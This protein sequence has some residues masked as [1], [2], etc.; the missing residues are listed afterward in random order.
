MRLSVPPGSF[1]EEGFVHNQT[2]D[3]VP[4]YARDVWVA[5][6]GIALR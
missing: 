2:D 6:Q 5:L 1:F 4:K 3:A